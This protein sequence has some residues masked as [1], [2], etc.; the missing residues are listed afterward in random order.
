MG[1][2]SFS[3]TV[4]M[5]LQPME[6]Q[7]S[8][9]THFSLPLM[10]GV[11]DLF[12]RLLSRRDRSPNILEG[13]EIFTVR[14]LISG[15][16]LEGIS[17]YLRSLI[18]DRR[19]ERLYDE[20]LREAVNG[21]NQN[22]LKRFLR[23]C[24][25]NLP[26]GTDTSA[27]FKVMKAALGWAV[28]N[29]D[30]RSVETIL[31]EAEELDRSGDLVR[32][33][34]KDDELMITLTDENCQR[35]ASALFRKGFRIHLS[36][37]DLTDI[38][39]LIS[40]KGPIVSNMHLLYLFNSS[41]CFVTCG[42]RNPDFQQECSL[43]VKESKK[44]RNQ[45]PFERFR[46]LKAYASPLY[47]SLMFLDTENTEGEQRKIQDPLRKLFACKSYAF[48]CSQTCD[49]QMMTEFRLIGEDCTKF[50]VKILDLLRYSDDVKI[51]LNHC[52]CEECEHLDRCENSNF[53]VALM[54]E[55]K[56][57]VAHYVVQQFLWEKMTGDNLDWFNYYL[58]WK[59]LLIPCYLILFL[60][61]PFVIVADF[62]READIL[63]VPPPKY[64]VGGVRELLGENILRTFGVQAE[65]EQETG[66][67]RFFREKIHRP[68]FRIF[69]HL[70][71]E[72]FFI[73]CLVLS[74]VDPLDV[75]GVKSIKWYDVLNV[76][77]ISFFLMDNLLELV[78]LRWKFFSSFIWNTYTITY[79]LLYMVGLLL[80]IQYLTSVNDDQR[81]RLGGN[82]S[83]NIGVALMAV[84]STMAMIGTIK[85]FLLI[86]SVGIVIIS[87]VRAFK[88]VFVM[89]GLFMIFFFS[90]ATAIFAL[91]KTY[92]GDTFRDPGQ[93][94][95]TFNKAITT[96]LWRFFDPGHPEDIEI[97]RNFTTDEIVEKILS[98]NDTIE[99]DLVIEIV[100]NSS[101]FKF[102]KEFGINSTTIEEGIIHQEF[103]QVIG[104]SFWA[105]YQGIVAIVMM[106]IL[107]ARITTNYTDIT[108]NED[109]EWKYKRSFI[110]AKFLPTHAALP[111]PFRI[112]YYIAFWVRK[113]RKTS[114]RQRVF[115]RSFQEQDAK[116]YHLMF[117]LIKLN[118]QMEKP[119]ES[120]RDHVIDFETINRRLQG[121]EMNQEIQT[122]TLK[123]F[124][125]FGIYDY[126]SKLTKSR[127]WT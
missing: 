9:Q 54:E 105:V 124:P 95:A 127:H 16:D 78:R 87:I 82:H 34:A 81:H 118:L 36:R 74:L 99:K 11:R 24:S 77:F 50:A 71:I 13:I 64:K 28:V 52:S 35:G 106:T 120:S 21:R 2:L 10:V 7:V 91:H 98:K 57:F 30:C 56:P 89:F 26:P 8:T 88:D 111:P 45:D 100:N 53:N 20:I 32:R 47:I 48:Y 65:Q 49:R 117:G 25:N 125:G 94:F 37:A 72:I 41:I 12:R 23:I 29:L 59:L 6:R 31:E 42:N 51:L 110:F 107:I 46:K 116:Y 103:V 92:S 109:M 4:E 93:N 113:C 1:V 83:I 108:Q 76:T 122:E 115:N 22:V 66:V 43:K 102:L 14:D 60:V 121:I 123:R 84:S 33:L 86:R 55:H 38:E 44:R 19:L 67:F 17:S 112:F 96:L 101:D 80:Q 119:Q 63:F 104:T 70:F 5:E 85:W 75:K 27:E 73:I 79:Q 90:F 62:F 40:V 97:R 15:G 114:S 126:R 3:Q 18:Q 39:N 61:F 58:H 68:L 69:F